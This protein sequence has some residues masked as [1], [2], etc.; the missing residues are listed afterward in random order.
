MWEILIYLLM[1]LRGFCPSLGGRGISSET[2]GAVLSATDLLCDLVIL[3][4]PLLM[5]S[6]YRNT[7]LL[8][9]TVGVKFISQ[10]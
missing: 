5:F 6:S 3:H 10:L 1:I 7:V 9:L 2:E 8:S 4:Q